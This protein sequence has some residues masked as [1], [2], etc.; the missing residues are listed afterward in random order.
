MRACATFDLAT[1]E[2][3]YRAGFSWRD[4]GFEQ[5]DDHPVL[6]VTWNDAQAYLKWLTEQTGR[7]YRLPT[8]AEYEYVARAGSPAKYPW[9]A[10]PNQG[11]R[12]ANVPDQ[13][14][15]PDGSHRQWIY[16]LECNDHYFFT[17]P[18][19]SYQA[20]AFGLYDMIG[21]AWSWTADCYHD[22]YA[23]APTDGSAWMAGDCLR[24]V[25]RGS[26]WG[27]NPAYLRVSARYRLVPT[28]RGDHIGFRLAQDL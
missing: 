24:R 9:G 18:V 15:W 21:N 1:G 22:S 8:E 23:G 27:G 13:T 6:C 10:D 26:A 12:Y 3:G 17:A 5:T 28:E 16:K 11:C 25:I 14:P 20:N 7:H 4:P 2:W 19:G